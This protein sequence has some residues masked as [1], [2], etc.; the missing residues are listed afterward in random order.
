MNK[1]HNISQATGTIIL[2]TVIFVSISR[3]IL[4]LFYIHFPWLLSTSA[5]AAIILTA[6]WSDY[7]L[8]ALKGFAVAAL[9][10]AVAVA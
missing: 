7:Y 8:T 5:L 10:L 9:M 3:S 1:I 6:I 4:S 2:L